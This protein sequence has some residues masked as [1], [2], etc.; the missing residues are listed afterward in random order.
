MQAGIVRPIFLCGIPLLDQ[1][2]FVRRYSLAEDG[3]QIRMVVLNLC[4]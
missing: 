1:A 4:Q 3:S 2:T